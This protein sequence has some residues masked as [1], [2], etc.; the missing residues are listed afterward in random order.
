MAESRQASTHC[1]PT[2]DSNARAD[3]LLNLKL[4]APAGVLLKACL[5]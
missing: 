2:R 1:Q 5:G 3:D 4:E